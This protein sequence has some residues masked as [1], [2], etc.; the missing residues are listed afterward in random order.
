M[1]PKKRLRLGTRRSDLAI[2]QSRIV[3]DALQA[4]PGRSEIELV[5]IVT[6]GDR[7]RG[8]LAEIG[9]KGLFTQ[10]LEAGLRSGDL[11][12]AVHSL[13]DLPAVVSEDLTLAAFPRRGPCWDVLVSEVASSVDELPD[14]ATVLTGSL[15]RGGLLLAQ[16][17]DLRI[18]GLRGN[19]ATRLE[20]WRESGAAGVVLAA[21]GLERLGYSD[22]PAHRL[23]PHSF[24]PAPGQ[25]TLVVETLSGSAAETLCRQIDHPETAAASAAERHIVRAF[26]ADCRLPLAAWARRTPSGESEGSGHLWSVSAWLGTADGARSLHA[27]ARHADATAAA[28][29]CVR[30]LRQLGVDELLPDL[31]P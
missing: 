8:P 16:R 1:S 15:R 13:K 23:D 27:D 14:G 29:E 21:A 7:E 9:G 19:V 6:R 24:L 30:R 10:E 31:L 12:L 2:A 18:V 28:E 4:L 20:R 3:A 25:G 26:G 11:D 22:L 5:P 17:P